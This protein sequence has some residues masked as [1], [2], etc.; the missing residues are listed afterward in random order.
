MEMVPNIHMLMCQNVEILTPQG[1]K[2][3]RGLLEV[4]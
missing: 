3:A 2:Y 1:P 4:I